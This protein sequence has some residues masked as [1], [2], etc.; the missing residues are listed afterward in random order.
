MFFGDII[1]QMMSVPL[2]DIANLMN[3]NIILTS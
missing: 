2:E 3:W 1:S